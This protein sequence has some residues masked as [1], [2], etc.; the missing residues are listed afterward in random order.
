[1]STKKT[2]KKKRTH[3]GPRRPEGPSLPEPSYGERA[4]TL[5][6]LVSK[7]AS[8][9]TLST[10]SKRHPGFPFGSLMPFA[11]DEEGR[12][13][14]LIS[15][16]AM[17]TQNLRADPRASLLVVEEA[18]EGDPLGAGRVT[19]VGNAA[20]VPLEEREAARELYLAVHPNARYWVDFGD[21]AF[22]R[23]E[24]VDLYFVG[25][26]G[27]MG[28]VEA[29]E[30]AEAGPDPL[31]EAAAGIIAHMNEDHEDA[32]E[33]LAR[34]HGEIGPEVSITEPRM[35]AVDRLGFF[36]KMKTDDRYRGLRINFPQP[37]ENPGEVRAAMVAMVKEARSQS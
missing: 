11:L 18:R 8:L 22:F 34:R 12:P 25:G 15:A 37:V 1:M 6:H 31:A 21:F 35:S 13:I 20:E 36:V 28:W 23:M 26:F 10:A 4:R 24:V 16:L 17:H 3:A 27:V 2:T 19:L 33:A 14:F 29:P 32:L 5:L 7:G 9:G 30:Y